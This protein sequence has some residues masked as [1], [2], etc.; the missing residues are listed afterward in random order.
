MCCAPA[1][2]SELFA[3]EG[4]KQEAVHK[5]RLRVGEGL[6]GDIASHAR[7][8]A[9]AAQ[10]HPQFAYRPETGGRDL[11][12]AD[13]RADPARRARARRPC[14][15]EPDPA[16]LRREEIETLETV[17]MVVAELIA[18]GELVGKGELA[19]EQGI[20]CCPPAWRA[21]WRQAW[22][23]ASP[24]CTSRTSRC[25]QLV[26]EDPNREIE[27]LDDAM[28]LM[29]LA[30]DDMLASSE[31]GGGGEHREILKP[32]AC[33]PKTRA[34]Q[35][36][37]EAIGT[38]LTAETAVQKVQNDTARPDARNQRSLY[39]RTP[40]RS[41]RSRQPVLRHLVGDAVQ[42]ASAICRTRAILVAATW[43]RRNC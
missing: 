37:L 13:G 36:I 5:T 21:R 31:D 7:P 25:K 41:R 20:A 8:L 40:G 10:H 3:T 6:I 17:A 14:G 26:A 27:R 12:V 2:C 35:P 38:G 23:A 28:S 39:P 9:L 15:A 30:L 42:P 4:L 34:G 16:Q 19:P 18:S 29:K 11:S 24:Y 43:V 22:R 33:S 1:R 32:T